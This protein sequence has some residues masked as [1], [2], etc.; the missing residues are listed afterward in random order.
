MSI[1]LDELVVK[2]GAAINAQGS[3]SSTLMQYRWAWSRFR[4]FCSHDGDAV[5][6]E[7]D[8]A[9]FVRFVADEHRAG[10]YKAWKAKLLRKAVLVLSEVAATGSYQWRL[11]KQTHPNDVLDAV[12]RPVQEQFETWLKGQGLAVATQ[13]LYATV[14]RRVLAWLPERG[15]NQ[16]GALTAPDVTAAVV[17]LGRHYRPGSMR[18]ALTALRVLCRFLEESQGCTGMSRAVPGRSVR[19]TGPVGVLDSHEVDELVAS[20]DPTAPAGLRDRAMLLLAARTGLRPVDIVNL[21]LGDIDWGLARITLTQHKTGTVLTLPLLADV[22]EAIADY[23]LHARPA[24]AGDDHVFLRSQAPFTALAPSS[25]LY[26]VASR[27]FARTGVTASNGTGHGFRVLRSSLATRML[28]GGTLLPVI[29]GTLGHRG[30]DSTKHYLAGDKN[31]MREC[32]LNF[33]GIEPRG[34]RS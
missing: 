16:I 19:R 2:A 14:A 9:S 20:A 25:D 21:H 5:F 17:F 6:T 31:R 33:A 28:E 24:S 15:V 12:F 3:A 13:N 29:S 34:A 27:A 22:G 30:I 10:R 8:A 11:S 7:A 4:S 1:S 18:T 32:C 23:L 26:F